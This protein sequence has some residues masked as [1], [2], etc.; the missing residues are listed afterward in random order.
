MRSNLVFA[1]SFS[2]PEFFGSVYYVPHFRLLLSTMETVKRSLLSVICSCECDRTTQKKNCGPHF[3]EIFRIDSLS[4]LDSQGRSS[5]K[6]FHP[7]QVRHTVWC[8]ET[9]FGA[10]TYY[11]DGM[12]RSSTDLPSRHLGGSVWIARPLWKANASGHFILALF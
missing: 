12:E 4:V 11:S 5:G 7:P 9:K 2:S 10:P 1:P 3:D 6:M 8:R